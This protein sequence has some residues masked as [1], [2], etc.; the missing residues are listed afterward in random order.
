[1]TKAY[2]TFEKLSEVPKNTLEVQV[3]VVDIV[4]MFR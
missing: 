1:M 3:S 4:C 2:R